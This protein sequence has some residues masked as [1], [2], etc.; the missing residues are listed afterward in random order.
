[1][2]AT[3]WR[4]ELKRRCGFSRGGRQSSAPARLPTNWPKPV[5]IEVYVSADGD[6][7]LHLDASWRAWWSAAGD[8]QLITR[9]MRQVSA[10][11]CGVAGAAGRGA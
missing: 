6:V 2:L 11:G 7:N 9:A 10:A 8:M 4:A 1:M 3:V 5:R